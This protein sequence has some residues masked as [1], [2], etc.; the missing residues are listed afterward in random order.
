[1]TNY[2][3]KCQS[4]SIEP[5]NQKSTLIA[6]FPYEYEDQE[7]V[8]NHH[9]EEHQLVYG[10]S[11]VMTV[12]TANQVF[13][14]PPQKAIWIPARTI[15]SNSI[16]GHVSMR[17]LFISPAYAK[18]ILDR[19]F[20]VE[21]SPLLRELILHICGMKHLLYGQAFDKNLAN[22]TL[23]LL[24]ESKEINLGLP[25]PKDLRALR[26]AE[27]MIQNPGS[28]KTVSEI[29]C[30]CGASLRTIERIFYVETGMT[31]GKWRQQL[32]L[33]HALRKIEDGY[34]VTDAALDS[35]YNSP[36]AFI[37]MYKKKFGTTPAKKMIVH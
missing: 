7:S 16:N 20:V 21:I 8:P 29:I 28:G 34:N 24:K 11:G 4:R 3:E 35:G 5:F 19:C 13:V 22:I 26:A 17:S 37:A 31:V 18:N 10:I 6:G 12:R 15:H 36:S 9:H 2:V 14:L 30:H 33:F 23:E 25:L 1:M 32:R 27:T